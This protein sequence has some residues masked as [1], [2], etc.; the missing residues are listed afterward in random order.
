[1]IPGAPDDPGSADAAAEEQEIE[2]L[3]DEI[4]GLLDDAS[5]T[6]TPAGYA[7]FTKRAAA[8]VA[9][10]AALEAGTSPGGDDLDE[11]VN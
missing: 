8:L 9:R 2:D 4:E 3:L 6:L 1:M 7:T 5:E 11:D 10:E